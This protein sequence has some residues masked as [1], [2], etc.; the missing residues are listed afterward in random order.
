LPSYSSAGSWLGCEKNGKK[1]VEEDINNVFGAAT[2]FSPRLIFNN[3]FLK[4]DMATGRITISY[5][6]YSPQL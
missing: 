3:Q 2:M 6:F 1:H 4:K 5:I